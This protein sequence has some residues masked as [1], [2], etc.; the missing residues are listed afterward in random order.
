MASRNVPQKETF[1]FEP[2][3]S[4]L[5]FSKEVESVRLS[6]YLYFYVGEECVNSS[7]C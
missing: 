6:F 4:Y 2:V 1:W 5:Y 3:L 7:T